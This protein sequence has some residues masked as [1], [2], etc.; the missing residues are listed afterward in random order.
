MYD[1]SVD[2]GPTRHAIT[3]GTIYLVD[4]SGN[5]NDAFA[6]L[7]FWAFP[8]SPTAQWTEDRVAKRIVYVARELNAAFTTD[9][10]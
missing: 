7:G 5:R 10:P 3:R 1:I 6:G 4:P 2:I 8:E 9:L